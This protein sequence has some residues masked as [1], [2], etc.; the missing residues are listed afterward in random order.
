M[1]RASELKIVSLLDNYLPPKIRDSVILQTLLENYVW[2]NSRKHV[3][4]FRLKSFD[5]T[6]S[7]LE[8]IYENLAIERPSNRPTDLNQTCINEILQSLHG[9]IILEVG[10][11]RGYLSELLSSRGKSVTSVD[12]VEPH[13]TPGYQ[14]VKGSVNS[15]PFEDAS[16]DTVVCAH[17][18]EHVPDIHGALDE[19]RR[20]TKSRLIIVLPRER[21]YRWGLNLHMHFFPY[22]WMLKPLFGQRTHSSTSFKDLGDWFCV[23]DKI[24]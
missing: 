20:V 12:Y 17:T 21:P 23:E 9:E 16:F 13:S 1:K 14:F 24:G 10:S 22:L 5:Y 18:L 6:D 3:K 8:K 2:K 15:L 19:L 11:G 7:D 4:D